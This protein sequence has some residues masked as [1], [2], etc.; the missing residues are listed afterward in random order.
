MRNVWALAGLTVLAMAIACSRNDKLPYGV[1][2]VDRTKVGEVKAVEIS[3]PVEEA[4]YQR[5]QVTTGKSPFLLAGEADGYRAALV[6]RFASLPDSAAV[7]RATLWLSPAAYRGAPAPITLTVHQVTEAW[8]EDSVRWEN[9]RGGEG[10]QVGS[11]SMV[12]GDTARIGI[13][14]ES[15]LVTGWIDSSVANYGL[16]VAASGAALQE[17]HSRQATDTTR[18]PKLEISY[19]R[20]GIAHTTLLLAS[21]DAF[22]V[23]FGGSP[24]P[25][26]LII[27]NATGWRVLLKFRLDSIPSDATINRARLELW[28]D[29]SSSKLRETGMAIGGRPVL[30]ESW[31]PPALQIDTT[32]SVPIAAL[33][34]GSE[35]LTFSVSSEIADFTAIVQAWTSGRLPNRGLA[36]YSTGEGLDASEAVLFSSEAGAAKTPRLLLEYTVPP[37]P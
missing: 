32:M 4:T 13:P 20:K 21:G 34:P 5:G 9:F 7:D 3:P 2:L 25:G 6:I 14:I 16:Y 36:L 24:P 18:Y 10:L 8:N 28:L 31:S 35:K 22:L 30:S 33:V 37:Q 27:G 29:Q 26:R 11:A 17:F 1:G 19:L 12:A 23:T 15:S